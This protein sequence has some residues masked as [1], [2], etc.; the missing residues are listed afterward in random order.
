MQFNTN[1]NEK[2]SIFNKTI[3]TFSIT[4]FCMERKYAMTNMPHGLVPGLNL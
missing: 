2:V 3:R 1:I 4:I